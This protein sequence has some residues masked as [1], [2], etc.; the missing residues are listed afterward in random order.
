MTSKIIT[1]F[2]FFTINLAAQISPGELTTAHADLEG[3]SN[4]TKCHELGEKVLNSKCLDCHSEI[5]SLMN[6]GEG[7]HSSG[8]VMGND[9]TKCHPE[10][11]GRN[12]KIV[13]FET[14][15]F[16]HEKTSYSLTGKHRTAECNACHQ[17][18]YISDPEI[19]KRSGTYLGLNSS[20]FSCHDDFHQQTLGDDC[21]ACHD[22]ENFRPAKKFN[23]DNLKFKLTG[24]HI[25]VNCIK[26]HPKS[27]KNGKEFQ[28]FT[29]LKYQNCS[30]CHSD[31]H[32][33]KF[34]LN[35]KNCHVTTSFAV[36]NKQWFD[37][38]KTN[39]PL[40]GKHRFVKCESCH[41]NDLKTKLYYQKCT[42]CHSDS[43]NSQFIIGNS[44]QDC[45]DCHTE[46]G[47]HPS[48][49]NIEKHNTFKFQ[50]TGAHLAIPC[51]NCHFENQNWNFRNLG[52]ECI[53][54]H[55]NIHETE[56][57][58]KYLPANECLECHSTESWS[59]INFNHDRTEFVLTGKHKYQTC[60]A[61]HYK[62]N[63]Y[64]L[65]D[66]IFKS[67]DKRCEVCHND[68]H[69]GQFK[70]GDVSDCTKCHGFFNWEAV[71]F[72]HEKTKFSVK[73]KH[74]KLQCISCHKVKE[75]NEFKFIQYRLEDFK[76]AS[77]HS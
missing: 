33:G 71:R 58:N 49:I 2:L 45:Y 3:L 29:G 14:A 70:I 20:C 5:R 32:K 61:C 59:T 73:G 23:H 53:G 52:L 8:D 50:L 40:M 68:I 27:Q 24:S 15:T 17:T 21:I 46:Y 63:K 38:N 41:K 48:I 57:V 69:N 72:D 47:F 1:C 42:D 28:K 7:Y 76:C 56:L 12:F 54:C 25:S 51:Q 43:H 30:S 19:K 18:K 37:H 62:V 66:L 34:G 22:T 67:L 60:R 44:L 10:H 77:C 35:C 39:F 74:A 16:D 65:N 9:C 64:G 13:N 55:N 75:R 26:C 6:F 4:C 31:V 11:F 36:I